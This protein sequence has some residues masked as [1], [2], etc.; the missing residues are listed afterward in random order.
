[1]DDETP[2]PGP[3]SPEAAAAAAS[4]V[5]EPAQAEAEGVDNVTIDHQ[6][7]VYTFP[8]SLESAPFD[9]VEAVDDQKLSYALRG[10]LSEDDFKYF[11]KHGSPTGGKPTVGDAARLFDVYAERIGLGSQ[12]E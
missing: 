4:G 9:V 8:G 11:Q 3:Q 1:M 7:H 2:Q 6:G 10:L 5:A 12:G